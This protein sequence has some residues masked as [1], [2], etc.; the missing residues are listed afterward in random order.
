MHPLFLL[1]IGTFVLVVGFLIWNRVSTG[2]HSFGQN[3]AGLGGEND[4][5]AGA[6]DDM[7]QPDAMR[8]SLDEAAS[9]PFR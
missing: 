2:R 6:T 5:L 9:K 8:A 3:P 4:P 7:R 1:A